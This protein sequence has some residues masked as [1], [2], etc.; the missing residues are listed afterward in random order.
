MGNKAR[1]Y[2]KSTIRK[3]DTLSCN[4]CANPDCDRKL[5]ARDGDTIVSKICHIEAVSP[6][7]PRF[8]PNMTDDERRDYDNLILLC[9]ECH[10]IIDNKKN[11]GKY[12]VD[13]L[14]KWKRDHENKCR[15]QQLSKKSTLLNQ[16]INAIAS[17]ELEDNLDNY[18]LETFN[19]DKKIEYNSIKE[20]RYIIEDCSKY[21]G[22]LNPLYSELEKQ[23][24]F[25]KE[26]LL[27]IIQNLYLKAKGEFVNGERN[28]L[29]MIQN[30]ADKIFKSV[31][32]KLWQLIDENQ[33]N[34]DDIYIALPIIMVDAFMRCKILEEPR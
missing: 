5:I 4:Q 24:S 25:R 26:K 18:S 3:L 34:T 7:G 20:Y 32:E 12:T 16:A 8:N 15:Q 14:K 19:I 23:G 1:Q 13:L 28:E 17:I 31:E 6:N 27:R 29:E 30:N 2:K 10:S 21:Y 9:D 22:K 33:S 11:E